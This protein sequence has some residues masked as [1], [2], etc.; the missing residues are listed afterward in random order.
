MW[1]RNGVQA[2]VKTMYLYASWSQWAKFISMLDDYSLQINSVSYSISTYAE[3]A[4]PYPI[5]I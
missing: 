4:A 1:N 3:W 5:T 2:Y